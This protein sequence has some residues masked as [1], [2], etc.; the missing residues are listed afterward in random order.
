MQHATELKYNRDRMAISK[1]D[2]NSN[3]MYARAIWPVQYSMSELHWSDQKWGK[4]FHIVS[5]YF[6]LFCS[7]IIPC[8]AAMETTYLPPQVVIPPKYLT[9]FMALVAAG[10]VTLATKRP[11]ALTSGTTMGPG[12]TRQ[13]DKPSVKCPDGGRALDNGKVY[14]RGFF[15]FLQLHVLQFCRNA[16]AKL[17][18]RPVLQRLQ[19]ALLHLTPSQE[20]HS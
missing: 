4:L 19:V 1:N 16:V 13:E 15:K 12:F 8:P 14:L 20:N 7:S 2:I 6:P 9:I 11:N 18:A 5:R 17:L 3:N 10:H